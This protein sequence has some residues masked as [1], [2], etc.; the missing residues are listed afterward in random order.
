MAGCNSF[1]QVRHNAR[2]SCQTASVYWVR[3]LVPKLTKSRPSAKNWSIISAACGDLNHY[4][5][6]GLV[7]IN[8]S[9][10]HELLCTPQFRRMLH[11][12]YHY[13]HISVAALDQFFK[14]PHFKMKC[15]GSRRSRR[16]PRNPSIGFGSM[17]SPSPPSI[18]LKLICGSIKCPYPHWFWIKS[19]NDCLDARYKF[20]DILI[21]LSFLL[22]TALDAL[23]DQVSYARSSGV[24]HRPAWVSRARAVASGMD[25]LTFTSV[26]SYRF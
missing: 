22:C 17:G 24:R 18:A 23:E 11:K 20:C 2:Y 1:I 26:A 25:T 10:A 12:R 8:S 4:P 15:S 19:I 6:L 9:F 14:C 5:D 7:K 16:M 13:S 3:S 21:S